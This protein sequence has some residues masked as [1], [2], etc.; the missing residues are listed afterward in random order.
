MIAKPMNNVT[1]DFTHATRDHRFQLSEE[2]PAIPD[3]VK[4]Q[5]IVAPTFIAMIIFLFV[6]KTYKPQIQ[7]FP[8]EPIKSAT[9]V[10]SA[11]TTCSV[12]TCGRFAFHQ[13]KS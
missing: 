11:Q 4:V 13:Q 3:D 8:S 2:T 9:E 7:F 12:T 10:S 1:K 6:W 5:V